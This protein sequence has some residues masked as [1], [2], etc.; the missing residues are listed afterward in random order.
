MK[1]KGA[2]FAMLGV[3]AGFGSAQFL[4]RSDSTVTTNLNSEVRANESASR[5]ADLERLVEGLTKQIAESRK[6]VTSAGTESIGATGANTAPTPAEIQ[7]MIEKGNSLLTKRNDDALLAAGFSQDRIKWIRRRAGE[8][9]AQRDQAMY[10]LSKSGGRKSY[11]ESFAYILDPD[12]DLA[13]EIGADEYDKYRQALG[14]PLGIVA[15]SVLPGS[16]AEKGGL[17][18]GDQIVSYSGIRTYNVGQLNYLA[19]IGTAS[20]VA[21]EVRRNG[22]TLTLVLPQGPVSIEGENPITHSRID[23]VPEANSAGGA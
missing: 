21:V 13:K 12:L 17:Q 5:I 3:A 16:N 14:R 7:K 9:Q 6:H 22:Q 10:A 19:R 11:D 15:L 4:H 8:L 2:I 1:Y 23:L 18:A 20:S